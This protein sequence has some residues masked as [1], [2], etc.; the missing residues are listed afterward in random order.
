MN[1]S[2]LLEQKLARWHDAI[3]DKRLIQENRIVWIENLRV[4]TE[5]MV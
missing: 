4:T 5:V 2:N 1:S 3:A